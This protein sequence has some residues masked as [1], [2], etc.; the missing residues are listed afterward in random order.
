MHVRLPVSVPAPRRRC[1]CEMRVERSSSRAA[2]I[3]QAHIEPSVSHALE[4]LRYRKD[5]RAPIPRPGPRDRWRVRPMRLR[6]RPQNVVRENVGLLT[7]NRVPHDPSGTYSRYPGGSGNA[8]H[9]S[10]S[11]L[12]THFSPTTRCRNTHWCVEAISALVGKGVPTI[13]PVSSA[14]SPVTPTKHSCSS[15]GIAC[16]RSF[17]PPGC[18]VTRPVG[19][20]TVDDNPLEVPERLCDQTLVV[21]QRVATILDCG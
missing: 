6:V 11:H 20:S 19:G 3:R 14:Q 16:Q 17:D 2:R 10:R 1:G 18:E 9:A 5:A 8:T 7:T 15:R 12:E 4:G 21:M 13:A